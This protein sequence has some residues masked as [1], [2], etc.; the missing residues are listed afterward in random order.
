MPP[1]LTDD[2]KFTEEA[3][4]LLAERFNATTGLLKYA[5]CSEQRAAIEDGIAYAPLATYG[6]QRQLLPLPTGI[7]FVIVTCAS[8][9]F[10]RIYA[11]KTL[12]PDL[13]EW[14]EPA[15]PSASGPPWGRISPGIG[16]PSS[17]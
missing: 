12:I 6:P 8:C 14:L 13:E 9:G 7:P 3:R 1:L 16:S 17:P 10:M 4:A 2:G 11:L 15:P 5:C